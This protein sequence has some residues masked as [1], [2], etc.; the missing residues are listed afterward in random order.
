MAKAKALCRVRRGHWIRSWIQRHTARARLLRN[1]AITIR[2]IADDLLSFDFNWSGKPNRQAV[3]RV[4]ENTDSYGTIGNHFPRNEGQYI[5]ADSCCTFH[6]LSQP[7][8]EPDTRA[9]AEASIVFHAP[10]S[11]R[12]LGRFRRT[13][14]F[15]LG[16]T[17]PSA[18]PASEYRGYNDFPEECLRQ[19]N[20]A[21][22]HGQSHKPTF[23]SD[24]RPSLRQYLLT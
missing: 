5:E 21:G 17:K 18:P 22:P 1:D 8:K 24:A 6:P 19:T 16:K 12:T 2:T 14:S 3:T 9:G 20:R 11:N 15:C 7:R 10:G 4:L 23:R 13:G